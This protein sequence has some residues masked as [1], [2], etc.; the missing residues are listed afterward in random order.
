MAAFVLVHGSGQN[1]SSWARVARAL[2]SKGHAVVAPDLPKRRPDWRLEEHAAHIGA[3]RTAAG[4]VVVAHSLCG[5][6]LPL[7]PQVEDCTL[8]VFLAAVIP[9]PGKSVRDQFT[10]DPGMFS[11][12]WIDAGPRW[13]DESQQAELARQ[14][15][16]HDCDEE[17]LPWALGTMETLDSR[18]LVTQK[19][20]ALQWP[21]V[22]AVSI[23]AT[24]DRTLSPAWGRRMSRRVLLSESLELD[25]G[26]CPHVSSPERTAH[27]LHD[28]ATR[29]VA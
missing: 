29:S 7:I 20:P 3:A 5:A 23:V 22:R 8:L 17:T 28:L 21:D 9:E 19:C 24:R 15:L 27:L 10:E 12:A 14:F 11:S 4:S 2:E 1:A 16:F 18:Q 26:H 6:F 13:F 25:A